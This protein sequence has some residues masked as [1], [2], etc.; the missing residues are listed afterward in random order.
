[1]LVPVKRDIE[2]FDAISHGEKILVIV[3]KLFTVRSYVK[4]CQLP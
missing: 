4:R 1:M 3:S 2:T